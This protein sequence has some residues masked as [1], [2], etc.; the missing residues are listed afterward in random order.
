[1]KTKFYEKVQRAS[2]MFFA[3]E[4]R[5]RIL[6]QTYNVLC[7]IWTNTRGAASS[8]KELVGRPLHP[9]YLVHNLF[10]FSLVKIWTNTNVLVS[11]K[12]PLSI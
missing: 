11:G 10:I 3:Q 8:D 6:K 1:M 9:G 7:I 4:N 2:K 5:I 12:T